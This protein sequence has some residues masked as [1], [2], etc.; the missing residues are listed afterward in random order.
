M[1][2]EH[3]LT[4]IQEIFIFWDS[5]PNCFLWDPLLDVN[6]ETAGI[7]EKITECT[8]SSGSRRETLCDLSFSLKTTLEFPY[9]YGRIIIQH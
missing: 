6:P 3:P 1:C 8:R 9:I 2:F 4:F 5:F 7:T